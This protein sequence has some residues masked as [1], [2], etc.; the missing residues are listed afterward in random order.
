MK[1]LEENIEQNIHRSLSSVPFLKEPK[2]SEFI[3]HEIDILKQTKNLSI[4]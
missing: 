3:R 1:T 4:W 2:L